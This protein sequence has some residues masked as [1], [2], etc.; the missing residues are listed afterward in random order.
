MG[1]R[2]G[3]RAL[4]VPADQVQPIR[5][6]L[7]RGSRIDED[8]CWIWLGCTNPDHGRIKI[9]GPTPR[10]EYAHRVSYAIHVAPLARG[11]LVLHSC[12]KPNCINPMHLRRGDYSDNNRDT[13]ARTRNRPRE[14]FPE[15]PPF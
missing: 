11:D 5:E 14:E 3:A 15:E 6:R 12:D 10:P 13:W 1:K 8:G 2:R 7:V 9:R 4:T